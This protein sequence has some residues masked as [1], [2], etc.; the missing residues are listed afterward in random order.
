[1]GIGE[2]RNVGQPCRLQCSPNGAGDVFVGGLPIDASIDVLVSSFL[3]CCNWNRVVAS[4]DLVNISH[5]T[6]LK[7]GI[8]LMVSIPGLISH[9]DVD[10]GSRGGKCV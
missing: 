6:Y 7:Q 3:F 4:E 10:T 9:G 2:T 5:F 1:M 8:V